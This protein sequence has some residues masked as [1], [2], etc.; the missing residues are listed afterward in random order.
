METFVRS[1]INEMVEEINRNGIIQSNKYE[2]VLDLPNVFRGEGIQQDPLMRELASIS[3]AKRLTVRCNSATI[4]GR[5]FTTQNYKFYGPQRQFPTEP[6]YS[7][8]ISFTYILSR[9]LRER[10]FFE[11]WMNLICNPLNYKFSFYK[12]YTTTATINI[13]DR[14]DNIIH[15]AIIEEI[16]P[17]QLGDLAVGYDKENEMMTQDVSFIYRKYTPLIVTQQIPPTEAI[18]PPTRQPM[19]PGSMSQIMSQLTDSNGD[20][21][22]QL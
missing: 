13:L 6:L 7:G 10:V 3:T 18:Q 14:M 22:L 19:L 2:V 8:E 16:Y 9:D 17:K 15:S 21:P 12:D 4:P 20:T 11:Q 5:S 1:N